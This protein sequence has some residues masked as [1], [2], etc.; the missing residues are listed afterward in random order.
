MH[1]IRTHLFPLLISPET[2]N[3]AKPKVAQHPSKN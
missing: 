2:R 1:E 3:K